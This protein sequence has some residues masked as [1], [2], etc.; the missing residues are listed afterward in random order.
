MLERAG[1]TA[2]AAK[3]SRVLLEKKRKAVEKE[4]VAPLSH[5]VTLAHKQVAEVNQKLEKAVAHFERLSE[6]L[7]QQR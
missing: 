7:E 3:H 4:C 5:R 2:T 1:D 6:G